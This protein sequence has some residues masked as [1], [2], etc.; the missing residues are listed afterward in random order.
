MEDLFQNVWGGQ[1]TIVYDNGLE[2]TV[3]VRFI[4]MIVIYLTLLSL[5]WPCLLLL[6]PG[7]V[8]VLVGKENSYHH[9]ATN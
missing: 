2:V 7:S 9:L 8:V 6:Q 1:Q 4:V 3:A 5:S